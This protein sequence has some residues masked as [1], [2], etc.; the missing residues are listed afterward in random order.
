MPRIQQNQGEYINALSCA[1]Y[2][3]NGEITNLSGQYLVQGSRDVLIKRDAQGGRGKVVS[4]FGY[5]L[6]GAAKTLNKR[7]ASEYV[8]QSSTGVERPLRRYHDEL[9]VLYDG[10]WR[11]VIDGLTGER[12]RFASY[13]VTGEQIDVL[14]MV[15]GTDTIREWS[16]SIAEIAE[17]TTTTLSKKGY[18]GASTIA[19][20]SS[21]RTLTDSASKFLTYG[22]AAGDTIIVSGSAANDGRYIIDT[23][24]ASTITLSADD[25]LSD[26]LAGAS[27]VVKLPVGTW[28]E[29]RAFASGTRK[30]TI[31]GIDYTYTGGE[32]TGTLTGVSASSGNPSSNGVTVGDLAIQTV[33]AYTPA[34]LDDYAIDLVSAF[35][36]HAVYGSHSSRVVYVSKNNDFD[37]FTETTPRAPGEG[38][39]IVLDAPP[40]AIVPTSQALYISAGRDYWYRITLALSADNAAEAI[41]VERLQ[42]AAGQAALNQEAVIPLKKSIAFLSAEGVL[43]ELATVEEVRTPS[44]LPLS[45]DIKD[46]LLAYDRTDAHAH[47]HLGVI[48][49]TL[50]NESVTLAYDVEQGFWQPPQFLA[51]SSTSV[52]AEVLCGHS[53][54]GNESYTLFTGLTDNGAPINHVAAFGYDRFGLD[55]WAKTADEFAAELY[56]NAATILTDRVVYDYLGASGSKDFL[57]DGS[58]DRITFIPNDSISLGTNPLGVHPLGSANAPIPAV[59]KVRVVNTTQALDFYERQRVFSSVG[60]YFEILGYGENAQQSEN[61]PGFII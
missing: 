49:L 40:T 31:D 6:L 22:F 55:L 17:V 51:L 53:S 1:G 26:E 34:T 9:E 19:F 7:I 44:R 16:G 33:R 4:R 29:A 10:A 50:P 23:V 5:E 25:T 38:F 46:D 52:I 2:I 15:E 43:E 56:L 3:S 57:I 18:Y 12:M 60:G 37:D 20:D 28:A 13:W 27:V 47:Y 30:F 8:W 54:A 32:D 24:T 61:E 48:Y 11:R 21:D 36:N 58:D 42:T 35:Q 39:E 45:H 41:E 14:L 59:A